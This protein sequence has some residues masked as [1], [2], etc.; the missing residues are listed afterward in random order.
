[1]LPIHRPASAR[2]GISLTDLC[3]V[4]VV[5]VL[6]FGATIPALL[7]TAG[8]SS[9][10]VKCA[11]NLRQIGLGMIMYANGERNGSFPRTY[12]NQDSSSLLSDTTGYNV[13]DGFNHE[14]GPSPV[15]DN[16][17]TASLFLL[18]KTMDITS[19]VFICPSTPGRP[20][21]TNGQ[22]A[23]S[24]A[25]VQNASNWASIPLNMTYSVNV[26]F[27]SRAA[28]PTGWRWN[29]ALSS[30][31]AIAAD[32]SSGA[33]GLTT[34]SPG[35]TPEQFRAVNSPNH[36][37]DGQ[38]VLFADGHVEFS[39]TPFCGAV[40]ASATAKDNVYTSGSS[41][42]T[43]GQMPVDSEDSVMLPVSD[44]KFQP[45]SNGLAS[46]DV[47]SLPLL[48]IVGCIAGAVILGGVVLAI[49]MASKRSAARSDNS[50][51]P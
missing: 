27:P 42:Q 50:P 10:R 35:A 46:I 32:I 49:V 31:F 33:Q 22:S 7:S 38:N 41:V 30:N 23:Q 29:Y 16:N 45:L 14:R 36:N 39:S 48:G 25:A 28:I 24:D 15:G 44:P 18:L 19:E 43:I 11:A 9:N 1:M 21:F 37:G 5:L 17:V 20:G 26:M 47:R 3:I 13:K 40:R 51:Q 6:L 34:I 8:E 12:F 4:L 2:H